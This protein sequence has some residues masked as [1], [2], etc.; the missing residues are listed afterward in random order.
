MSSPE[1]VTANR[2]RLRTRKRR[3]E[4]FVELYK[5]RRHTHGQRVDDASREL[6]RIDV[7]LETCR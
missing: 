3:L 2:K 5:L 6:E 4:N 7:V 1:A